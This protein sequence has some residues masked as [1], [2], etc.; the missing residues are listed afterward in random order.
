META[1]LSDRPEDAA[2]RVPDM[3]QLVHAT[4]SAIESY[5]TQVSA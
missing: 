1:L 2:A 3:A 5:R 4:R